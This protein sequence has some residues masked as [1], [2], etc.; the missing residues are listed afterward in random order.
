MSLGCYKTII[1]VQECKANWTSNQVS[2]QQPWVVVH[3]LALLF[4]PL[5]F[6]MSASL[7]LSPALPV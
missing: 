5:G 6:Y 2:V 4:L 7:K 1:N 3:Y